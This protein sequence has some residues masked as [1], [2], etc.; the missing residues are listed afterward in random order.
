MFPNVASPE[1]LG[2]DLNASYLLQNNNSG[3]K[4]FKKNSQDTAVFFCASKVRVLYGPNTSVNS[5]REGD[6]LLFLVLLGS[7]LIDENQRKYSIKLSAVTS[8]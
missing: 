4:I 7:K 1:K 2:D 8:L 5:K 3:L 6:F